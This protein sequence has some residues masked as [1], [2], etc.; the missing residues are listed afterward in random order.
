M[1]VIFTN[2]EEILQ[3]Q[4]IQETPA[5]FRVLIVAAKGHNSQATRERIGNKFVDT[6][7]EGIATE[8]RFVDSID[9]TPTGKCRPVISKCTRSSFNEA[10]TT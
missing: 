7:G 2:E 9:R 4:V 10:T 5:R 8:I 1:R 3:Y 6:F